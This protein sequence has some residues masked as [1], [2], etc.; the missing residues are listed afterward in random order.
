MPQIKYDTD[1]IRDIAIRCTEKLHKSGWS[2]ETDWFEVQD[3]I[4]NEVAKSL[5]VTL[6]PKSGKSR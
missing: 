3:T 4:F 5:W 1:E 6:T 2:K